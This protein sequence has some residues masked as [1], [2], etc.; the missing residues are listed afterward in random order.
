M[1]ERFTKSARQTVVNTCKAA[2]RLGQGRVR[3]E[4][5]L[6]GIAATE[7]TVGARVLAGFGIDA[8]RLEQAMTARDRRPALSESEIDALRAVGIDAEEVYRRIEEAFG[9]PDWFLVAE[10]TPAPDERR[11]SGK[12][13]GG[14]LDG[15]TRQ[16]LA[17]S[18]RE[19]IMLKHRGIGSEHILLALLASTAAS[20]MDV[21]AEHGVTYQDARERVL[22]A[23]R[24]ACPR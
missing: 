9:D 2:D 16:I 7:D 12:I 18:M 19:A 21:L 10:P 11:L 3:P 4:H 17:R 6:L 13:G 8:P 1:F 23:L 15:Q 22:D 24:L 5:L 14:R 20:R